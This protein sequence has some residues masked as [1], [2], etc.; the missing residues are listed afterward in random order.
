[1]QGQRAPAS[2]QDVTLFYQRLTR[3]G[4]VWVFKQLSDHERSNNYRIT[5]GTDWNKKAP[6]H[7]HASGST[8]TCAA[9]VIK[10]YSTV[11]GMP[12]CAPH[13]PLIPTHCNRRWRCAGPNNADPSPMHAFDANSLNRG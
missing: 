13:V 1:M 2:V 3:S 12:A 8:A 9:L 4:V 11:T 7:D 5:R 6:T 10:I